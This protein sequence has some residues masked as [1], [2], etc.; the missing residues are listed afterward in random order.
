MTSKVYKD[1]MSA[2]A[3][4]SSG[5]SIMSGGFGLCGIAE[6]CIDALSKMD[7]NNLSIISNN[8]GN[9]GRGLVKI[10]VQNKISNAYCSYVG[11]NPDLEKQMLDGSVK[12]EL[13]PQGTFSERIRA[14]GL[15]IRAFYTPT[16]YGTLIA[17][18]KDVKEFDRPCILEEALHAD[19]AIIKAQKADPYGNLWFKETARN[20]SPLMAMAAKVTIV[21]VE[22]LVGLGE[23]RAEDIHLPGIFVQ[24]IFQ[25][26]NYKNDIE[27]LKTQD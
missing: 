21:E 8:I 14:A 15:G 4:I 16:G 7:I 26:T 24:R 9:S 23:L 13:I 17:E 1:A 3:D 12:V 18:G 25:G 11:G 27:F 20:F 5:S 2:C 22:Q 19:Y 10:L 6:N